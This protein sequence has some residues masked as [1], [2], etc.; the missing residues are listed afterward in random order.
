MGEFVGAKRLRS[1]HLRSQHVRRR[2]G[3][4]PRALPQAPPQLHGGAV[5]STIMKVHP[6]ASARAAKRARSWARRNA[7]SITIDHPLVRPVQA[8]CHNASYVRVC[9]SGE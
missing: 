8:A 6:A 2:L 9:A 5:H 7:A 3:G 4:I 1:C